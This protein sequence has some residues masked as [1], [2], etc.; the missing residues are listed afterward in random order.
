MLDDK[1]MTKF[2]Q[3]VHDEMQTEAEVLKY[4]AK[5]LKYVINLKEFQ[6]VPKTIKEES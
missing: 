4:D 5:C 6:P 1:L 3:K 2:Q